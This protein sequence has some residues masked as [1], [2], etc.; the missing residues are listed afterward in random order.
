MKSDR[1]YALSTRDK[2]RWAF[3]PRNSASE[4]KMVRDLR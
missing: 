1:I 4:S 2:D 3:I